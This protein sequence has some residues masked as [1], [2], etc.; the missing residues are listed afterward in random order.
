MAGDWIPYCKDLPR[1][2]EVLAIAE[3]AGMTVAE[4]VLALLTFWSWVDEQS[5]DGR[6]GHASVTLLSHVCPAISVTFA[7]SMVR[8]GWLRF[9]EG[10]AEVVNFDAWMGNSA[11]KRLQAAMRKRRSRDRLP[12]ASRSSVTKARHKRDQGVTTEQN[13]TEQEKNTPLPPKL[14]T[15][16]F[17]AAWKRWLS[18]RE[19]MRKPLKPAS[20]EALLKKLSGW[21]ADQAIRSIDESIANGWQGLFERAIDGRDTTAGR[22]GRVESPPG[23]Y[24]GVGRVVSSDLFGDPCPPLAPG[25]GAGGGAGP[26]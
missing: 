17:R 14:D 26:F 22:P 19:Q 25:Q 21:G 11:K 7:E 18:Y 1:K 16:E 3:A 9:G 5:A 15:P 8:V 20:L 10:Y 6:I 23:K 13:R 2:P 12:N 24:D 4:T